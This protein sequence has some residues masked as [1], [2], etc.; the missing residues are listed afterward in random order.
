VR[1]TERH[2]SPNY[3]ILHRTQSSHISRASQHGRWTVAYKG[4]CTW[5][6]R[7]GAVG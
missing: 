6:G 3:L 5:D 4:L 7:R 1:N 2:P